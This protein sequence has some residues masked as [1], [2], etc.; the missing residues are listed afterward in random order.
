MAIEIIN[1]IEIPVNDLSRARKF[2][3]TVFQFTIVDLKV[4]DEVYPCFPNKKGD[5]FTGALIQNKVTAPG[6]R[7]PL[8]Y[9]ISYGNMDSML[10]RI[11][12][13]GGKIIEPKKE[14][15]PGFGYYAIFEDSEGNLLALQDS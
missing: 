3:E 14:I 9:F 6:N 2:Y 4:G 15:A 5:G 10:D 7:G 11:K 8:V 1:W 13:A 12:M